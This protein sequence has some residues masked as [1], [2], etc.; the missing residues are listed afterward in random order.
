MGVGLGVAMTVVGWTDLA[1]LWIPPHFGR[2]EWEFGTIS[3]H[4]DGLALGTVGLVFLSI[5]VVRNGW[6]LGMR[7]LALAC[8]TVTLALIAISVIYLLDVPIALQGAAPQ[9]HPILK[10]AMLK[11]GVFAMTYIGL[12]GWMTAYLWRAARRPRPDLEED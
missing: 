3:R 4:F 11:C 12:Y 10:K 1:L 5:G 7:G 2:A 9:V 6:G 8:L